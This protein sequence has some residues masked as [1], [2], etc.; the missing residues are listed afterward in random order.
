MLMPTAVLKL[1]SA[2]ELESGEQSAVQADLHH[3]RSIYF[4]LIAALDDGVSPELC[5]QL[6]NLYTWCVRELMA[7][8][9]NHDIAK[10][11]AVKR[12]TITLQEAWQEAVEQNTL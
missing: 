8:G 1:E 7:A 6:R 2:C 10:V 3:V 5:G 12:V 9:R 4:E 11:Q